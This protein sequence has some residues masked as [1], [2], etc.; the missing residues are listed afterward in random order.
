MLPNYCPECRRDRAFKFWYEGTT[1]PV[2]IALASA[3]AVVQARFSAI[4][5]AFDRTLTEPA[6]VT[7]LTLGNARGRFDY[8]AVGTVSNVA[9]RRG[10]TEPD[11]HQPAC[12]DE[13]RKC[14]EGRAGR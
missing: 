12:I 9:L 14:G 2:T 1:F 3:T 8:V 11:F 6:V 5:A 13:G 4:L 10:K 7:P